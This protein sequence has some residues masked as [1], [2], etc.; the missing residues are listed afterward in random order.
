MPPQ[1]GSRYATCIAIR[2]DAGR[3]VLSERAPFAYRAF[4]DNRVH[5]VVQG[6][7]LWHL[8]GR[9]FVPLPRPAGLWWVLCDFQ[10]EPIV[11]P[12]VALDVGRRLYVPS[13]ATLERA[14]AGAPYVGGP[15]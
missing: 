7:T 14:L 5:A 3:L 10:P 9:Y 8:A 12:T 6:D 15:A 4:V 13:I 11:D 2:D 1:A